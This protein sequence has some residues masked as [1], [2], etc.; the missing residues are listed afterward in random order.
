MR[1]TSHYHA[2]EASMKRIN[3]SL[4]SVTTFLH[5]AASSVLLEYFFGP[6]TSSLVMAHSIV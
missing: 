2:S 5:R 4:F 6:T 3:F 1:V